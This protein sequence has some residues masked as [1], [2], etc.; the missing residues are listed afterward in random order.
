MVDLHWEWHG[1]V[2]ACPWGVCKE[3]KPHRRVPMVHRRERRTHRRERRAHR[4]L[5]I[6]VERMAGRGLA[7]AVADRGLAV[8]H[9]KGKGRRR[10]ALVAHRNHNQ[11]GH[12]GIQTFCR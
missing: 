8:V 9:R 4:R 1:V 12:G 6:E 5:R 11:M 2:E 10:A 3:L 7:V